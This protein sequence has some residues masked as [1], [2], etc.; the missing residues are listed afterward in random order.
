[1]G[2]CLFG[3]FGN[4]THVPFREAKVK[5]QEEAAALAFGLVLKSTQFPEVRRAALKI[6]SSCR[7]RDDMCELKAIYNAVKTGT[8][9]VPGLEKGVRYVSDPDGDDDS[10]NDY[11]TAPDRLLEMCQDGACG[12]DCDDQSILVASLAMQLGF[13][14]GLRIW[15]PDNGRHFEHIYCVIGLPK[16]APDHA[17]AMDTTVSEAYVGWEP[18][19]GYVKTVALANQKW[20]NQ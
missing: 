4:R 6:V 16:L 8:D 9:A 10:G 19:D 2:A 7:D 14:V 15:K 12:G 13:Q 11:F 17:V 20:V 5:T 1:M 3:I 18:R